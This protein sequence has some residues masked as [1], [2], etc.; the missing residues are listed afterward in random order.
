MF[1]LHLWS[2]VVDRLD[3]EEFSNVFFAIRVSKKDDIT[4]PLNEWTCKL[5]MIG[6]TEPGQVCAYFEGR[7]SVLRAVPTMVKS[8]AGLESSELL[9]VTYDE[10]E[11]EFM[12]RYSGYSIVKAADI[13][14]ED[15]YSDA[16]SAVSGDSD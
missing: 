16:G 10:R 3:P 4:V 6:M 14:Y 13:P 8:L 9:V 7:R 12:K 5:V 11:F 2:L 1:D 15:D